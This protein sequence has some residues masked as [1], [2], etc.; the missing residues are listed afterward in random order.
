[1]TKY[2][3][4]NEMIARTHCTAYANGEMD[5]CDGVGLTAVSVVLT[6]L[7]IFFSSVMPC[8]I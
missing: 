8:F 7:M 5:F 1:M 3:Y 6:D 4:L 2:L